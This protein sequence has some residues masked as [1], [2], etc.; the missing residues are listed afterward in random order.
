MVH[1]PTN[2][3]LGIWVIILIMQVWGKYMILCG[4]LRLRVYLAQDLG[5]RVCCQ[6]AR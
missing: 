4:G 6:T 1:T 2:L 5:F 3:V